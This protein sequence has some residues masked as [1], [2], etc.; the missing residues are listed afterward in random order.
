VGIPR[1]RIMLSAQHKDWIIIVTCLACIV[2]PPLF[3]S[4]DLLSIVLNHGYSPLLHTISAFAIQPY[5][6]IERVGIFTMGLTLIGVGIVWFFWLARR[7][8]VL[9]RIAG[10]LLGLVGLGFML[11]GAF[12]TDVISLDK[13]LH[14]VIHYYTFV[15]MLALFPCFCI[16]LALSLRRRLFNRKG[17]A[18]YTGIT[19]LIGLFF[20][21]SR[22]IPVLNSVPSGLAERLIASVDLFWLTIA[23]SQITRLARVT[24]QLEGPP[25]VSSKKRLK[26]FG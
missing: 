23:G 19:G 9:F 5:G 12:N 24:G 1:H 22:I 10:A 25:E 18:L 21:A 2:V 11:I 3:F 4:Y 7:V 6:W 13:S 20:I 26:V 16:V 14:G 17:V 8:G 15:A